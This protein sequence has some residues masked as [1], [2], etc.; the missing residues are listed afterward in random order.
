ME[1]KIETAK[2]EE[3]LNGACLGMDQT[4]ISDGLPL[5]AIGPGALQRPE[6]LPRQ[7]EDLLIQEGIRGQCCSTLQSEEG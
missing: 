4:N 5:K 2:G 7:P 1:V 3:K 6:C